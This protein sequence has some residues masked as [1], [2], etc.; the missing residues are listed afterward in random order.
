MNVRHGF[1]KALLVFTVLWATGFSRSSASWA[2]E[3]MQ[4]PCPARAVTVRGDSL[5]PLLPHGSDVMM[6]P[7][8]CARFSHGPVRRG[9]LVIFHT[10][11]RAQPVIKIV[12]GLPGDRFAVDLDGFIIVNGVI[13]KNSAGAAYRPPVRG[14]AMLLAYRDGYGGVIP[15]GAYLLLGDNANSVIDSTRLGLIHVSD[16]IM[17]GP[18]REASD[19]GQGGGRP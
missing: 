11:A 2:Q 13:L 1:Y 5:S 12:R 19:G 15:A 8:A 7:A 9:D 10:G 4:D 3:G 18:G 16:F 14:R 6:K 17:T